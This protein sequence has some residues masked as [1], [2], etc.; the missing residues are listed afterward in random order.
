MVKTYHRPGRVEEV[1]RLLADEQD[2][3]VPLAGGTTLALNPRGVDGLVDLAALKLSYI[4]VDKGTL[5]IGATTPIR[6]IQRS[7]PVRQF[8]Q[9]I[10]AESAKNYLTALIR[11]RATLGGILAG[12]NFWADIV[13][14]LVALQARVKIVSMGGDGRLKETGVS[15]EDFMN[16]SPR[17]SLAGGIVQEVSV[18]ACEGNCFCAYNRLAKV[19]TDISILSAAARIRRSG[20]TVQSGILVVSNGERPLRLKLAEE[21]IAGRPIAAAIEIAVQAARNIP[22]ESDIRASAEY[23]REVA[24]VLVKRL[25]QN[26]R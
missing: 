18:P 5:V 1:L 26:L 8:A 13:T 4:R 7:E 21:K 22:A 19:E 6:E 23:R 12:G 9:G 16:K 24:G 20:E 2:K 10:L 17:K 11:N 25:I 3:N 14:V 15:V